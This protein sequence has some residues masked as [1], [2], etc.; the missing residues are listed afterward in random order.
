MKKLLAFL[1]AMVLC[2]TCFAAC[3]DKK[4]PAN[5]IIKNIQQ[6]EKRGYLNLLSKNV[7]TH[8]SSHQDRNN[9]TNTS[10]IKKRIIYN[11]KLT[12]SNRSSN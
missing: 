7:V 2:L 10:A 3:G 4:E 6:K 5:N 12:S 8:S 9:I 11:T 1:V